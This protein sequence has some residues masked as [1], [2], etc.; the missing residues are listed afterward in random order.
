MGQFELLAG[1]CEDDVVFADIVPAA[2]RSKP[3]A[4][5]GHSFRDHDRLTR[6]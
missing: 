1:G 6:Y 3:I 5:A 4:S 2:Q